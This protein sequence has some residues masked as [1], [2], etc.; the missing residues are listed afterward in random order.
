MRLAEDTRR[1]ERSKA[2]GRRQR[3]QPWRYLEGRGISKDIP[4]SRCEHCEPIA[5]LQEEAGDE[6]F[7]VDGYPI[8]RRSAT[9]VGI[10]EGS[11]R[12]E[13]KGD[14]TAH[15]D[16]MQKGSVFRF[17][18]LPAELRNSICELAFSRP[19]QPVCI[20][21]RLL[22]P[23]A[24][25]GSTRDVVRTCYSDLVCLPCQLHDLVGIPCNSL[26]RVNQQLHRETA[27]T[28]Y[29]VN[30]FSA[31][32]LYYLQAFL[33]LIGADARQHLRSLRF[34]WKLPEEEAHSLGLYTATTTTYRLLGECT[35][36]VRLDVEMDINN[37][38][39]WKGSGDGRERMLGY[40]HEV[41]NI[42][43]MHELRGLKD[44]KLSWRRLEGFEGMHGWTVETELREAESSTTEYVH[45]RADGDE[46]DGE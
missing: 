30:T 40:L 27:F 21:D 31:H 18:D 46:A 25:P 20:A 39:A 42:E 43:W 17:L 9:T 11:S 22:R 34:I 28:A 8:G 14:T 6:F 44:V 45:W 4:E 1:K 10:Q 3:E 35:A 2:F 41:P 12:S 13:A 37:L 23:S 26:S 38:L 16:P 24:G 29:T 7:D 33:K 36:L 15:V 5:S 32:N 19:E